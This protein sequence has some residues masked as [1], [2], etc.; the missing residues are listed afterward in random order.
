MVLCEPNGQMNLNLSPL[1]TAILW[2]CREREREREREWEGGGEGL[3]YTHVLQ[4]ALLATAGSGREG[5]G[6]S[7]MQRTS[8]SYQPPARDESAGALLALCYLPQ[9]LTLRALHI[10]YMYT[11]TCTAMQ[12][13]FL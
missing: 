9:Q 6:I 13:P 11:F 12:L 8:S 5:G 2:L 10:P 4:L 3:F 1:L 7:Y